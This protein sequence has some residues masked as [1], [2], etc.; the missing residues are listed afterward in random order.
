MENNAAPPERA[1]RC[2]NGTRKVTQCLCILCRIFVPLIFSIWN[3]VPGAETIDSRL[4]DKSIEPTISTPP[5]KEPSATVPSC[6]AWRQ[7]I[8]M[9]IRRHLSSILAFGI[10]LSCRA[11]LLAGPRDGQWKKVEEAI[12]HGLPKTAITNLE[13]IIQASLKDKAYAEAVKAIGKKIA[14]EGNIQGN[15]PEEKITRL[16][17]EIAKAPREMVPVMDTLLAHWYWQY[18]QQNR[19]RF[20]QRTTTAQ[21]PGKDFT[22]WDLP[23]LFNEID[24][25][26]QS[27]LAAEPTLK[28][29]PIA[30]WDDLLQKGT[31]PDSFRPTLFDFIAHEALDFY[32]SGEQVATKAQDAFE[33]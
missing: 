9:R 18:F 4:I 33:L 30:F 20:L 32:T 22:T 27:A 2:Q 29:T 21:A 6:T 10:L 23:R 24:K 15:K 19:W 12:S 13:P 3:V 26:F 28:A 8:F 1:L 25:Q 7:L 11:A 5:M 31:M 16:E 17:A 14:L